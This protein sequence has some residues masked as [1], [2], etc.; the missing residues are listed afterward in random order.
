MALTI[1]L[2]THHCIIYKHILG[3]GT[4]I[5]TQIFTSDAPPAPVPLAGTLCA[6]ER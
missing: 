2:P 6:T 1:I 4:F 5:P 3:R